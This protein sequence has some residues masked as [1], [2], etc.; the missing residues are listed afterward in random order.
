MLS[1]FRRT[2]GRRSM[3]KHAEKERLREAQRAATHIPAAGD[4]KSIITCRVS[5]L[6]GTD[7]SVDLPKK[8]KGQELFDQIMYHLDLIESDYFGLRFMDSAQ[9]A[10][11]NCFI[12]MF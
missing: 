7:V 2:L 11:S 12:W 10:V 4:S 3:R 9:V 8:A 5:L 6:D 1:F